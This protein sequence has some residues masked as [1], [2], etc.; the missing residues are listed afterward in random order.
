MIIS[1]PFNTFIARFL[2][3]SPFEQYLQQA[4]L[5]INEKSVIEI[6]EYVK[7]QQLQSGA[8]MDKAGNADLYYTL[9]GYFISEALSINSVVEKTK[10]YINQLHV[11]DIKT[12][13]DLFC[14][15]ILFSIYYP[16]EQK[17]SEIHVKVNKL[18]QENNNNKSLYLHFMGLVSLFYL[19]NYFRLFLHLLKI[20][21]LLQSDI[22]EK[23]ASIVS[24][25][26]VL[27]K[28]SGKR[29]KMQ[30]KQLTGF[31]RKSGGFAA[32]K[33]APVEDI[34][35]TAVGLFA[36]NYA[37]VDLSVIKPK[38]INFINQLYHKGGFKATVFD[39]ESDV[40]YTFYGLLALASL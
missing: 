40:E 6:K 29:I 33:K 5:I 9:F 28:T 27:R 3:I 11:K 34:L 30:L 20:R 13:I 22:N 19:R 26:I 14:A 16:N 18:L 12:E 37:K 2:Q 8:F 15:S 7:S 4:L 36:L 1:K 31:Y 38:T 10:N 32:L 23:P 17:T 25:E 35:S 39:M 21:K 24:A